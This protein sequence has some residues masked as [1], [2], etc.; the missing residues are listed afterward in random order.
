[1]LIY[2]NSTKYLLSSITKTKLITYSFLGQ[3]FLFVF[4]ISPENNKSDSNADFS[5]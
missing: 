5:C 1:M 3:L 4:V 2:V